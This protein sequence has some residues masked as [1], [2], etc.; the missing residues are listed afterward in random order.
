MEDRI[1]LSRT[2]LDA[3]DAREP[4]SSDD[5][6]IL[7]LHELCENVGQWC[8]QSGL[9]RNETL[10]SLRRLVRAGL[11][12]PTEEAIKLYGDSSVI[13]M[14]RDQMT[15]VSEILEQTG[16]SNDTSDLSEVPT[17]VRSPSSDDLLRSKTSDWDDIPSVE[18]E[19]DST[20]TLTDSEFYFAPDDD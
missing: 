6:F 15:M 7:Q 20:P 1:V 10:K 3:E 14:G 9:K 17:R 8:A 4:I 11:L 19:E 18:V 5:F 2:E 13:L 16:F 12:E